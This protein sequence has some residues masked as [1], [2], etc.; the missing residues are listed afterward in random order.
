MAGGLVWLV[1]A[2]WA[3]NGQGAAEAPGFWGDT[4]W[5]GA[6]KRRER[7]E[8]KGGESWRGAEGR[9]EKPGE[10]WKRW[11]GLPE[12][13]RKILRERAKK[14]RREAQ[15]RLL[16][17][18]EER[19][20][21]LPPERHRGF[22]EA[23]WKGRREIE[24]S[25]REEFHRKRQELEEALFDR[26]VREFGAGT[27]AGTWEAPLPEQRRRPFPDAEKEIFEQP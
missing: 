22:L 19:G 1:P 21:T 24:R 18:L 13:E 25:L 8:R 20:I 3:Q 17:R 23:Y 12:E 5:Q 26:L 10:N 15:E 16:Q 27:P 14:M 9:A 11:Q 6:E 2:V 4:V 7:P